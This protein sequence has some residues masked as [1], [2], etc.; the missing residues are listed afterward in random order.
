MLDEAGISQGVVL[1]MAYTFADERKNV[2]NP[3]AHV[4]AENNWTADQV[5]RANGRLVGF[6][7]VNPLRQA[8]VAELKRCSQLPGMIGLKLHF[9]NSGVDLRNPA[10]LASIERIFAASDGMRFPIVVH[11]RSRS[12][13]PYGEEYG[14]LFLKRL[15]PA[16]PHVVV[17]VAHLAGNGGYADDADAVMGVFASAMAQRDPRTRN[18]Y[19]DV[20]AAVVPDTTPAE[21]NRIARRI[22]EVGVRRILFG[23]DLPLGGNLAAKQSW[24]VFRT[25]VPLTSAQFRQIAANIAP[26]MRHRK[27]GSASHP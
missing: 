27:G 12:T 11:M 25:K 6:C 21:A 10:H 7:G 13:S 9:G 16:A 19:F 24:E 15:L 8:A 23:S 4:A 14:R 2:P 26:Y 18:L 5:S 17:Q 3:D 1:S 20:T 22:R